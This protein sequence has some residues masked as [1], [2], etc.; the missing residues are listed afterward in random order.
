MV[1]DRLA[2][3]VLDLLKRQN[4][5]AK[6]EWLAKIGMRRRRP[7][8][9]PR[10]DDGLSA[11]CFLSRELALSLDDGSARGARAAANFAELSQ[12]VRAILGKQH[13][14]LAVRLQETYRCFDPHGRQPHLPQQLQPPLRT[15]AEAS[16][17]SEMLHTSL[18]SAG[19]RLCSKDDEVAALH[20]HFGNEY[21]WN[22]PAEVSWSE[23]NGSLV[24]RQ[25]GG[26]DA[27]AAEEAAGRRV[28]RPS[29]AHKIAVYTRGVGIVE[30]RGYFLGAKVEELMTR[31]ARAVVSLAFRALR[32]LVNPV[33]RS[34]DA[35]AGKARRGLVAAA[36]PVA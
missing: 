21:M 17:F 32:A 9:V 5:L 15:A 31:R 14:E 27:Y 4:W 12:L 23:L 33:E 30:K 29:W 34:V 11:V 16:A 25:L 3:S 24:Q 28:G 19:F 7:H 6:S 2:K 1:R 8:R 36:A 20:G 10:P 35:A 22:V 13:H 18:R 26:F